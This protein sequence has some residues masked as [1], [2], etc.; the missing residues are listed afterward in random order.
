MPVH[1]SDVAA[2]FEEI[3][4]LL[5]IQG[6][7]RFRVRSYRD[8]AQTVSGMSRDVGDMV[9]EDE[10]LTELSGIGD[11]LAGKIVEFVEEGEVEKL[12]ELRDDVPSGLREMMKVEGLGPKRTAKLWETLKV[13]S[14]DELET[15]A[16]EGRIQ[17]VD[18]FGEKS[19][20]NILEGIARARQSDDER[21]RIDRAEERVEALLDYMRE[22]ESIDRIAPAG[23][24]RRR[25]ETVGDIDLL[26]SCDEG[27][28]V[29]EHFVDYDDVDRVELQGE[30]KSTVYLRNGLQVDL[31]VV[32]DACFGAAMKYFTGSK[33]HNVACRKRGV[34]RDLKINEYGVFREDELVGGRT[35]EEIYE[36]IEMDY[37]EPELRENRGE[38]EA[39]VDGELP[40]LI[41]RADLRGDLHMHTSASDGRDELE[42]M[43]ERAHEL[44]HDYIGI[45][46]H[47][48]ASTVAGGL[49]PDELRE[50]GEAIR[51]LDEELDDLKVFRSCE[52]DILRDGSLDLNDDIRE[53]L[54]YTI[55]SVHSAFGLD[56]DEQTERIVRAIRH[57]HSDVIGHP[58][59]RKIGVREPYPVDVERII[60]AAAEHGVAV[61]LNAQ[62]ARLDLSDAHCKLAKE[63]GV[64]VLLST[65]SHRTDH[66]EAMHYG[67]GQARRGWLEPSDVLNTRELDELTAFF[68]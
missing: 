1:N 61:E 41:E 51:R 50:Q 68:D 49:E 66:L 55:C 38:V 46:D 7:N 25:K 24:Y 39:A 31:R 33:E 54:D 67:I 13:D 60:E 19:E 48:Q 12:E 29:M 6:A 27:E 21:T 56:R 28:A 14:L 62:P 45:T 32:D 63:R 43:V 64:P 3:A 34:A 30:T 15:A 11:S 17:E 10:D 22:L 16:E 44:G 52:V 47:S 26:V 37:V 35:E 18:G 65:D 20:Q 9:R 4:D 23:S 42:A 36:L 8:A 57:P 2:M 58:T 5:E 53:E 40:D 59:G